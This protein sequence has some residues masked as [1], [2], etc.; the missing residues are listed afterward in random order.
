MRARARIEAIHDPAA[1][2]KLAELDELAALCAGVW[3]DATAER[4]SYS[5]GSTARVT[6]TAVSRLGQP[7]S[8]LYEGAEKPLA[9]NEPW[10]AR[11]EWKVP[12]DAPLSQPFW[13]ANAKQG[14]LYGVNDARRIGD[15][16]NPPEKTVEF[17]LK[18]LGQ[19]VTV[20]R[21]VIHRYVDPARGEL[22]RAVIIAPATA[23]EFAE[24]VIVFPDS[25]PHTVQVQVKATQPAQSG[26]VRLEAPAGWKVSPAEREFKLNTG[27]QSTVAFELTPP[28][29]DSVATL[30]A[31][32]NGSPYAIREINY[33]HIPPQTLFPPA[34]VKLVRADIRTL[35]RS[36]GYVM[37]AGDDVPAALKQLG[38]SVT[39][40]SDDD[41]AASD[42]SRFDAIVA[43]VRA[44]NT[45]PA[46]KANHQRLLDYMNNG[47]TYVVQYNVV[48]GFPGRERRDALS[49]IGPYPITIDRAR[50]TVE[51][52]PVNF[53]N[54]EHRLLQAPNKITAQDFNGWV[55]ERG[56]YF[57]SQYDGKYESLF[58]SHDPG[59]DWLPG[60][61]L[62]AR[63]GKGAYVFSAYAWFRQL[64]AGVPGAFRIFANLLSAGKQ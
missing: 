34:E 46:L 42:L 1:E 30:R 52:A 51:E 31:L 17:K 60:G 38:I 25:K 3:L 20:R 41:L 6:L 63:F 21:P 5:P 47:G 14:T 49:R 8:I 61:M 35:S 13:L 4:F 10:T 9:D 57:A 43:G 55:Q 27:E 48:E 33:P 50:V 24:S 26:S 2:G 22:T 56:L 23:V 19:P 18:I 62:Y 28:A 64:P 32:V 37:G 15:A 7:V 39:L 59:E 53:P 44:Y 54:P 16:E 36:V 40:L 12:A 29:A 45:R 11:L 58:A